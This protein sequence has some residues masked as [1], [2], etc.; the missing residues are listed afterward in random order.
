MNFYRY[1]VAVC[2][3]TSFRIVL[4]YVLVLLKEFIRMNQ[5]IPLVIIIIFSS[6]TANA[7]IDLLSKGT[8]YVRVTNDAN[9]IVVVDVVLDGVGKD[10]T[11]KTIQP[12]E[13]TQI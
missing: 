2:A 6:F 4:F 1:T 13:V 10:I 9:Y 8:H 5:I 7:I 12:S 3:Y 11:S